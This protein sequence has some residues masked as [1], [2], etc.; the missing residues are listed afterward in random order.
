MAS[1]WRSSAF[2][3]GALGGAWVNAHTASLMPLG[4]NFHRY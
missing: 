1:G 4:I 3:H 2:D